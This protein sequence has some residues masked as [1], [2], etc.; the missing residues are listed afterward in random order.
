MDLAWP[1]EDGREDHQTDRER[2]G[3]P[4]AYLVRLFRE[5]VPPNQNEPWG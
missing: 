3:W 2:K 5:R 1:T 4:G